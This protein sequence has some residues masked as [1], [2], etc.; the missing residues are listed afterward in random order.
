M[1][2]RSLLVSSALFLTLT[3][4]L[5]PVSNTHTLANIGIQQDEE[6]DK[7]APYVTFHSPTNDSVYITP[8][9]DVQAHVV[10]NYTHNETESR[11]FLAVLGYSAGERDLAVFIDETYV[12]MLGLADSKNQ[13]FWPGTHNITILAGA[14]GSGYPNMT[15]RSSAI[16]EV[17]DYDSPPPTTNETTKA[18]VTVSADD[19]ILSFS[20]LPMVVAAIPVIAVSIWKRRRY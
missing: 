11:Y 18:T 16:F 14:W 3:I 10:L 13:W 9:H 19:G 6:L 12:G 4:L 17:Y 7:D 2:A 8:A 5:Q 20:L 15:V 1:K